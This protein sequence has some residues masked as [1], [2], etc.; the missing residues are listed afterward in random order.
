MAGATEVQY[1]VLPDSTRPYL[2]AR[3]R[4]PDVA[5]AISAACP[6][7]QEDPGLF[8]L[9]YDPAGVKVTPYQAAAIAA[10]WGARLPSG[11]TVEKLGPTLVRRMPANWSE[12]SPAEKRAWSLE[13]VTRS[14]RASARQDGARLRGAH[15][16]RRR[17]RSLL[18]AFR[19]PFRRPELAPEARSAEPA[20]APL[21]TLARAENRAQVI[22]PM[23]INLTGT[24]EVVSTHRGLALVSMEDGNSSEPDGS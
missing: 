5:Q 4:W 2:L 7:W 15:S 24:T 12:L 21:H 10:S 19:H 23:T 22:G 14:R 8:D 9:P 3:V 1:L 6:E 17:H 16:G 18:W 13:L 20:G 11:A